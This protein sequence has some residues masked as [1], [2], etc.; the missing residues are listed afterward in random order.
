MGIINKNSNSKLQNTTPSSQW[1]KNKLTLIPLKPTHAA[2]KPSAAVPV[3][4]PALAT[5]NAVERRLPRPLAAVK[6]ATNAVKE[7]THAA[8]KEDAATMVA[9][10]SATVTVQRLNSQSLQPH[11]D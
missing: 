10:V 2:T 3:N 4:K 11:S 6:L 9:I 1:S 8:L 7:L 5:V